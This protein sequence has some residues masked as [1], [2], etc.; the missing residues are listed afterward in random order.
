MLE[1][2]AVRLLLTYKV[3]FSKADHEHLKALV[4]C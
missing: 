4:P 1:I 3:S 2:A